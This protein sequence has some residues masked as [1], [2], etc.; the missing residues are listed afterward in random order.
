M[1]VLGSTEALATYKANPYSG[2]PNRDELDDRLAHFTLPAVKPKFKL[3]AHDRVFTIGSCFARNIENALVETGRTIAGRDLW[4]N[5]G[6]VD[7]N[8][9]SSIL[10]NF[11][12]SSIENELDWAFGEARF[13]VEEHC[14]QYANG[15]WQDLHIPQAIKASRL[16]L[17]EQRRD[18]IHKTYRLLESSSFIII[19]LGLVEAWFDKKAQKY[20][21]LTPP[22]EA[23][24]QHPKRFELHVQSVDFIRQTLF[25]IVSKLKAI[26]P[27][28]HK[29]LITVSPIPL[30]AS[31][32][33]R[34]VIVANA[35][36][37]AALRVAAEE[38]YQEHT[39]IDYFPSFESITHT[40]RSVAYLNDQVHVN[41]DLIGANV[42]HMMSLYSEAV[43]LETFEQLRQ[44]LHAL[45][46]QER[47]V[48]LGKFLV[49]NP[50]H[51]GAILTC[52]EVA[53]T[54]RKLMRL[55]EKYIAKLPAKL[56]LR[57]AISL[58]N[59]YLRLNTPERVI[60]LLSS[61]TFGKNKSAI[62]A[63]GRA[64]NQTGQFSK[65]V[66]VLER[67]PHSGAGPRALIAMELAKALRHL[68]R[69]KE[70]REQMEIAKE[71]RPADKKVKAAEQELFGFFA[72]TSRFYEKAVMRPKAKS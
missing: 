10:N 7:R 63:I 57:E 70:A 46:P 26:C 13:N 36:S 64:F 8:N 50:D 30:T 3:E 65:A 17:L 19:T 38:L 12:V 51:T 52:V 28:G 1:K 54:N 47:L 2:W 32:T 40:D 4:L 14:Y 58:S 34:D 25:R 72:K 66:D 31:F 5:S 53:T 21:N 48:Q 27:E 29:I 37:K 24:R 39:H 11:A 6:L 16:D 62:Y 15:K 61:I 22:K 69:N 45:P 60:E 18:L 49:K 20:L 71:L 9:P 55:A 43:N 56:N 44:A 41:T 35:Y 23:I 67:S 33:D 59:S 42:R 68:G